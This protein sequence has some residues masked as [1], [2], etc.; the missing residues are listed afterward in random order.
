MITSVTAF[1]PATVANVAVGFD[2]L[3]FALESVGDKVTLEK[4]LKSKEVNILSIIGLEGLPLDPQKN[5]ATIGLLKMIADLELPYGFNVKIEKGIPISSGMGGSAASSVAAITAANEFLEK[6]LNRTELLIYAL[7]GEKAASGAIHA[8]NVA[9]SLFG[10]LTLIRSLEPI[11][12]IE[13]PTPSLFCVLV[14]PDIKVETKYSRSVLKPEISMNKFIQQSTHLASFISGCFKNDL[15]LI[16]RSCIDFIIEEQRA[17]L[18]PGFYE[19]KKAAMDNSALACSISGSGPSLF[20][21]AK[22]EK[23]AAQIK[24]EMIK[25]FQNNGI[26]KLDSWVSPIN[27]NGSYIIE[28]I[29]K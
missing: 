12:I 10:G 23:E 5:T 13:I 21:L 27:K 7:E 6:P 26:L 9:P 20:A 16:K 17:H 29:K 15:D 4:N 22:N 11:D 3:G 2:I 24:D 1:A 25:S 18:I 28:R 19:V 8:D 14:H